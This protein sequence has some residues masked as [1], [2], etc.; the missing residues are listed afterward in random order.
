MYKQ[1][2]VIFSF[3]ISTREFQERKKHT[4]VVDFDNGEGAEFNIFSG[5]GGI[6]S[7]R[8]VNRIVTLTNV[9]KVLAPR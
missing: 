4:K 7:S 5:T 3:T 1:K 8:F 9:E 6:Y 2:L